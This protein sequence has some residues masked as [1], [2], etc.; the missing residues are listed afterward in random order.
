MNRSLKLL[1]ALPLLAT[2]ALAAARETQ[3]CRIRIMRPLADDTGRRWNAGQ[4][5]PADFI[6]KDDQGTFYCEDH[7]ACVPQRSNGAV[8]TRPID[9]RA[10]KAISAETFYLDPIP[11]VMGA[12]AA[13]QMLT[14]RRAEERLSALGFSNAAAGTF[15]EDYASAPS[16]RNGRLVARA[17][18][19]SRT[20]IANLKRILQ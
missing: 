14:R 8:V 18:A 4:I 9:C 3:E 16:S 15:A 17:L 10:G 12:S 13:R 2:P 1:L 11:A 6:R 20:A 7:G 5:V 19:G